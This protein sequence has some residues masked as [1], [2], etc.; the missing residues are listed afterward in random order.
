M[1]TFFPTSSTPEYAEIISLKSNLD[2]MTHNWE[3]AKNQLH[4]TRV[5]I[6]NVQDYIYDIMSGDGS[7]DDD[8]R[9]IAALLDIHLTKNVQISGTVSFS[10]SVEVAI[11]FDEAEIDFDADISELFDADDCDINI[12]NIDWDVK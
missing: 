6:D 8:I 1:E 10:C 3:F 7:I 5:K 11:D 4:E 2:T 12:D 9:A